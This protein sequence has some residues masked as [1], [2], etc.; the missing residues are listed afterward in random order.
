MQAEDALD[1]A[2]AAPVRDCVRQ[3]PGDCLEA[4]PGG[5]AGPTQL[6]EFEII[7]HQA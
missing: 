1:P 2:L 5:V 7:L 3:F 6:I 4:H